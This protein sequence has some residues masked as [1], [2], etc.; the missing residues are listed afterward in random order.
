MTSV[1]KELLEQKTNDEVL[2]E[3]VSFNTLYYIIELD[4]EKF[5]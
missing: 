3:P 2:D 5:K 4:I 1:S